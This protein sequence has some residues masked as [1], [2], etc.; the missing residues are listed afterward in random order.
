MKVCLISPWEQ[1]LGL[2]SIATCIKDIAETKI[3]DLPALKWDIDDI[4]KFLTDYKPEIIGFTSMTQNFPQMIK[5]AKMT[6]KILPKSLIVFGGIHATVRPQDP[7]KYKFVDLVVRD[8]GEITF[9]EIIKTIKAK[10][11]YKKIKGISYKIKNKIINNEKRELINNLNKLPEID[12]S[13]LPMNYRYGK[14]KIPYAHIITSKGCKGRCLFCIHSKKL[15]GEGFRT[16]SAINVY[17]EIKNIHDKYNIEF[18]RIIDDNLTYDRERIIKLCNLITKN[19]LK[20]Y[21]DLPNGTRADTVDL[22]LLKKMKKAGCFC[23]HYGI[24]SGNQQIVYKMGKG[25]TLKQVEDAIKNTKKA[26]IRTGGFF[27]LGN[28]YEN[29][30]TI[31]DTINFSKKLNCD[32]TTFYVCTP[33]PGTIL[34]DIIEKKGKHLF[35]NKWELYNVNGD[36]SLSIGDIDYKLIKKYYSKA[37]KEFYLRPKTVISLAKRIL[38]PINKIDF[39]Y[40]LDTLINMFGSIKQMLK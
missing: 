30:S 22:E 36:P 7:L 5:I 9:K 24:E 14:F 33:Y 37:F 21:W 32:H 19:K 4:K 26:G 28:L 25:T 23:I 3:I 34:W 12:R 6:K 1:P 2:A 38:F 20:I 29:E 10:K 18:F 17:N 11:D 39:L 8:E 27:M 40:N 13:F 16:R 35:G 15:Q 31:R